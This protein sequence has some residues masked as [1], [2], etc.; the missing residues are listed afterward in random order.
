MKNPDVGVLDLS[1]LNGLKTAQRA[2]KKK[3][4]QSTVQEP[5]HKSLQYLQGHV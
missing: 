4:D 5:H 3:K 1:R 2:A